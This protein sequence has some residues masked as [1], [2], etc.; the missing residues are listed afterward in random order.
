MTRVGSV[1]R[2]RWQCGY[3]G[4]ALLRVGEMRRRTV[5]GFMAFT[6]D[7]VPTQEPRYRCKDDV[8]CLRRQR[9]RVGGTP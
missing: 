8:A 4:Y 2:V 3:C 7:E 6:E 5:I 9:H 1:R